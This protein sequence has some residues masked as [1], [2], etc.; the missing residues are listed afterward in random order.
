[1]AGA[2]QI[3]VSAELRVISGGADAEMITLPV[4]GARE[5]R[6]ATEQVLLHR[7]EAFEGETTRFGVL[8]AGEAQ[9]RCEIHQ[10]DRAGG[11]DGARGF[12]LPPR[13]LFLENPFETLVNAVP[14]ARVT[15]TCSGG[16]FY[17]Y[18]TVLDEIAGFQ[19]VE[20]AVRLEAGF[21]G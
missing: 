5:A 8:N 6:G 9:V 19:F 12:N 15:V 10:F 4:V 7:L 14:T 21:G 2:P 18:A 3:S 13:S 16:P 1:V 20:P 17:A 11:E